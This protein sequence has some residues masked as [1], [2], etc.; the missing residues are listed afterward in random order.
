MREL[1]KYIIE[2][3]QK[4]STNDIY[5]SSHWTKRKGHK[6]IY[7][8]LVPFLRKVPKPKL[9]THIHLNFYFRSY[10]LDCDNCSYMVKLFIDCLIEAEVIP[11]DCTKNVRAITITSQKKGKQ[12]ELEF[13]FK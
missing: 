12:D 6:D 8:Q 2:L 1:D 13:Y 9:P 5:K 4:L 10:P 11:N 7:R 3:P